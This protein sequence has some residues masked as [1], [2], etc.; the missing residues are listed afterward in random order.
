MKQLISILLLSFV[1][2]SPCYSQSLDGFKV[3]KINRQVKEY[4]LDSINLSSPLNYY[5]SRALVRLSGKNKNWQ[6]ISSSKFSYDTD[7]PDDEVDDQLRA[8]VLNESI[9]YIA[10]YRD[11][12]ATIVTHTDGEDLVM[13]NNC[14]LENG[15]WVNIG[16]N[17]ADDNSEAEEKILNQLPIALYNLPRIDVINHI[18]EDVAPF[19]EFLSNVSTSPE[20]FLLY[21]LSTHKLVINGEFHRRKASWDMLKRLISMP[22]FADVAGCVFMELPSHHQPL[23]DEFF[24]GD[25]INTDIIIKIFQDEQPNGWWDRGEF[26]FLC[27]L[28]EINHSLPQSKKI[29]VVLADYQV[30][31][32]EITTREE[33]R[34]LE[35][36]NSH[37]ADVIAN[38]IAQSA[39]SRN[40]LFLVGCAHAYKSNQNGLASAA[41][42]KENQL[43]AGAQL[44]DRLGNDN[45]F[46]IF[47]H[48][49]S[50]DNGG[51]NRSA[52][53]GGI[54]D[55]AFERN[56]NRPVGFS[57]AN[58]PF[59]REPFDGIY[60]IKYN[61]ATGTYADNFDG[62]LF[63]GP[64]SSEP[65]A[66]P[67][68]EVFTDE[69]VAEMQRRAT[70]LRIE[71]A[72]WL[73]F[74]RRSTDLTKEYIIN[75]LLQE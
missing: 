19:S 65:K 8:Y 6:A 64:L 41:Y 50:G 47:Q 39:D 40:N 74:G 67:L 62:Y 59:G 75:T 44:A 43:T 13:L 28:W 2:W 1:C 37:M 36:R 73:W 56:G 34:E 17:I 29:R 70:V 69:F 23:I 54:F 26:E 33:A 20:A 60:E 68:T 58:S 45:V 12:V 25:T 48:V 4:Q 38:A 11:S 15:K 42:G 7:A 21:M 30:P 49:L 24:N 5:I 66:I 46:T 52:I 9:D 27:K 10:T 51:K 14:W 61:T 32:S 63:L 31:Y 57:L 35:D 72:S 53:R 18:P 55:M 16:Q 71:N 3:D 22:E